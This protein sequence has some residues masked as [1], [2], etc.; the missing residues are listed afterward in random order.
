V[1]PPL[2]G[3]ELPISPNA[4][5]EEVLTREQAAFLDQLE[6]E[7]RANT[8]ANV[9]DLL[10]PDVELTEISSRRYSEPIRE[11]PESGQVNLVAQIDAILQKHVAA[12]DLLAHRSIHL[13]QTQGDHLQIIVDGEVYHHPND[14]EDEGVK[15]ALKRAL[16]EWETR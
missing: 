16:Q 9:P 7:V 13:R 14:I 15:R 2:P 12:S 3:S 6:R 1:A 5:D 8:L 11:A 4:Q 10:S